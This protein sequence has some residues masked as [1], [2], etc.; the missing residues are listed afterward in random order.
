MDIKV[1]TVGPRIIGI[2]DKD[3]FKLT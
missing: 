3:M 1:A 2:I